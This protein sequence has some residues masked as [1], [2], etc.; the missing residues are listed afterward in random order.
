VCST[1]LISSRDLARWRDENFIASKRIRSKPVESSAIFFSV[2][3][4]G[5]VYPMMYDGSKHAWNVLD[6]TLQDPQPCVFD[7]APTTSSL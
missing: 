3:H 4:H 5:S 7:S 1:T 6:G 2:R